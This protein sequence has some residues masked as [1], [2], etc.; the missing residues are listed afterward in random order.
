VPDREIDAQGGMN[1]RALVTKLAVGA[2]A[3]PAIVAFKLDSL[4]RAGTFSKHHEKK[5]PDCHMPNGT[6]ANGTMP[7]GEIPPPDD[8][9]H[10]K[11][12]KHDPPSPP[13]DDGGHKKHKKDDEHKKHD[14]PS[15]SH[16]DGGR[17]RIKKKK[18]RHEQ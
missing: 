11:H 14:D 8:G 17:K 13:D 12:K 15:T 6:L 7:D 5:G 9:G 18:K 3:V 2:F 1:R 10:K 16:S 4:A